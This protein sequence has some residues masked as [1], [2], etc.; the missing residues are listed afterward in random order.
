MDDANGPGTH[1]VS[2]HNIGTTC[3]YFDSYGVIPPKE[4]VQFMKQSKKKI[5]YNIYR[6][7]SFTSFLCGYYC[8]DFV[9]SMLNGMT[10][11]DW[12][13][14]YDPKHFQKND[15]KVLRNLNV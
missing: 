12:L 5:L 9:E 1:W 6:I 2:V 15:E 11:M 8:I 13:L 7:Q 14:Q 4:I 10:Y 3:L